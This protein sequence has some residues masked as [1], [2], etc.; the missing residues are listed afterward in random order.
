MASGPDLSV[1]SR[2]AAAVHRHSPVPLHHQIKIAVLQ[3]VEEGWLAPGEQLPRERELAEAIGVSLA[4]VRQAMAD[5]TKEGYVERTRGKGTFIRDRKLVEKIQILG[6]FHDS[7]SRQGLNVTVKVLSSEMARPPHAVASALALRGRDAW[8]LRRLALLDGDPLTLLTAWLP[9][10]YAR[11]VSDLDLG[12]GSLYEALARVHAVE[13]TAADSLV[14]VDRAGLDQAELLGLAPGSPVLRVI[15]I[16]RDQQ[17]RPVEY[18]DVLYRPERF[19]LAIESRRTTPASQLHNQTPDQAP[20]QSLSQTH[21]P[22]GA[23]RRQQVPG[24]SHGQ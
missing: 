2:L 4:P 7:V 15:G 22:G 13:M 6:S 23:S 10:R 12:G 17:D 14:E 18:S 5:L 21:S 24:G 19:R 20:S 1:R 16:T 8:C 11:G 9:P 3:G